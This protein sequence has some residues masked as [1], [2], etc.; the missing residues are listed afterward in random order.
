MGHSAELRWELQEGLSRSVIRP[1]LCF[2]E[3]HP[4]SCGGGTVGERVESE[5][6]GG[7]VIS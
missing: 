2:L 7:C 3:G 5:H 6:L 4:G 1:D